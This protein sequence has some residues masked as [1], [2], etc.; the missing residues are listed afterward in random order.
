MILS[1]HA[2]AGAAAGLLLTQDPISAFTAGIIS[3][4]LLDMIPHWHY[5]LRSRVR[6]EGDRIK[7]KLLIRE[8]TGLFLFDL[9]IMGS[10]C[11]L[12]FLAVVWAGINAD[13][14][15]TVALAGAIGGVLPDFLQFVY[16]LYPHTPMRQIQRAHK[17]IHAKQDLDHK[18]FLG[19]GS[20]A[21]IILVF[22]WLIVR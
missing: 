2:V 10:E 9:A 5:R 15:L 7:E 6:P 21:A 16:H 12:G 17:W 8:R 11:L 19:I 13:A 18:P 3:H 22:L 20:Q 14:D 4:A 1:T